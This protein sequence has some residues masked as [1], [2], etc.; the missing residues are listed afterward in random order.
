MKI[1]LLYYSCKFKY[2][3]YILLFLHITIGLV[4]LKIMNEVFKF[5][6]VALY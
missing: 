6:H 1:N 3:Y 2:D 4:L 5:L